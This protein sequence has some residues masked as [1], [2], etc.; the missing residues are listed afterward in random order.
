MQRYVATNQLYFYLGCAALFLSI[1]VMSP[2]LHSGYIYDDNINSMINGILSYQR[3]TVFQYFYDIIYNNWFLTLGRFFP[4]SVYAYLLD[5]FVT[6]VFLYKLIILISVIFTLLLFGYFVYLLTKSKALFVLSLLVIP[7]F[8]QFRLYHDPI[9]GYH[10]LLQVLF[11]LLLLSLIFL[12]H[13]LE[14]GRT[15]YLGLSA[16]F[17]LLCLLTYDISYPFFILHLVLI[18][19]YKKKVSLTEII[20]KGSPFIL[21]S[22]VLVSYV[23]VMRLLNGSALIGSSTG[24]AYVPNFDLLSI[25]GTL[26]NQS[27]SAIPLSYYFLNPQN[28]FADSVGIF[29]TGFSLDYIFIGVMY[30]TLFYLLS[31]EL[32]REIKNGGIINPLN[33][34]L[35]GISL[36]I[37]PGIIISFSPKYQRDILPGLGYIPVYISYFGAALVALALLF[38]LYHRYADNRRVLTLLFIIFSLASSMIGIINYSTNNTVVEISDVTFY[39]PRELI[40]SGISNGLFSE[41]PKGSRLLIDS[42]YFCDIPPFYNM[43]TNQTLN[44][45]SSKNVL[46]YGGTPFLENLSQDAVVTS[47]GT[48]VLYNFTDSDSVYYLHYSSQSKDQGYAM[49]GRVRE[50]L[51]TNYAIYGAD[52]N[53][54]TLYV[55]DTNFKNPPAMSNNPVLYGNV[56]EVNGLWKVG[57]GSFSSFTLRED[58]MHNL[59][60]GKDWRLVTY[61]SDKII[62]F[63]ALHVDVVSEYRSPSYLNVANTANFLLNDND[64]LFHAGFPDGYVQNGLDFNPIA[65]N[66]SFTL[67]FIVNPAQIQNDFAD[68]LG[69][70]PDYLNFGGFVVQQESTLDNV[71][72]YSY[73]NG[74]EFV[75]PL[76]FELTSNELN[77]VAITQDS[78]RT[79]LYKNGKLMEEVNTTSHLKNSLMP[80]YVGNWINGDRPFNGKIFE[81]KITNQA[82]PEETVVRNWANLHHSFP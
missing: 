39:Y 53:T 11:T 51:A 50:L 55:F 48:R 22:G 3:I 37:V 76:R 64:S 33:I 16:V 43:L 41:I 58:Q 29:W 15:R 26:I 78:N 31:R 69:N 49:V 62:D 4:L 25:V 82:I 20:R 68:I 70:H 28:V 67:E 61:T 14:T 71:Y 77:Y 44:I 12:M 19:L 66:S 60:S 32:Y 38:Y 1:V 74:E 54:I 80:F 52:G 35:V 30:F 79:R 40:T 9:L 13:Y 34:S 46:W 56:I 10:A 7:L 6:N 36:W 59:S 24:N 2:M 47:S 73:G 27:V 65:V 18:L 8:F 63:K 57:N 75:S 42:Y 21:L 72:Y 81:V 17:Y 45:S 23:I 5:F